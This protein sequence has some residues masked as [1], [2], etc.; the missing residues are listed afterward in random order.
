M[1]GKYV[2]GAF[3]MTLA[4]LWAAGPSDNVQ[5]SPHAPSAPPSSNAVGSILSQLVNP[6]NPTIEA[7]LPIHKSYKAAAH[8][9]V[10]ERE[11]VLALLRSPNLTD[12]YLGWSYLD[13]KVRAQPSENAQKQVVSQYGFGTTKAFYNDYDKALADMTGQGLQDTTL[14]MDRLALRN[15]GVVEDT[16]RKMLI[17]MLGLAQKNQRDDRAIRALLKI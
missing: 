14:I 5:I 6:Q 9:G 3:G 17:Q 4:G 10:S 12:K 16:D 2:L 8:P 7:S 1:K 15:L 11:D 13:E